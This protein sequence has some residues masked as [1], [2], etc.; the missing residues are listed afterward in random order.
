MKEE[1]LMGLGIFTAIA[2]GLCCIT[3]VLAMLAGIGGIAATFSWIEPF[4]PYLIGLSVFVLGF[5]WY[6][7]LKP[8][9]D[10]DCVCDDENPGFWQGKSFLGLISVFAVLMMAFPIYSGIFYG[11]NIKASE[12]PTSNIAPGV[13]SNEKYANVVYA[14]DG[15]T[16]SSCEHHIESVVSKL[17]G[18][19]K[20]NASFKDGNATVSFDKEKVSEKQIKEAI[21]STGYTVRESAES[22]QKEPEKFE[23]VVVAVDGMTCSS[24]ERPIEDAVSKLD[25][26]SKVKASYRDRQATITFDKSKTNAEQV[27]KTINSTGFT[28]KPE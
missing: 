26:V 17:D 9:S 15:M 21:D 13:E 18:V 10:V 4:R 8:K 19:E 24:C 22:N 3:P 14:I 20:V 27:K 1:K 5:A 12:N 7:K 6:Q 25:G 16:C 23:K 11:T 28:V 2:A